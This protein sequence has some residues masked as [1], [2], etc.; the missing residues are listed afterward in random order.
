MVLPLLSMRESVHEAAS[1]SP[2]CVPSIHGSDTQVL[3]CISTLLESQNH[4]SRMFAMKLPN[5]SPLLESMQISLCCAACLATDH[6]ERFVSALPPVC[7]PE[8]SDPHTA[9]IQVHA[10]TGRDATMAQFCK[11]GNYQNLAGTATHIHAC[12]N[13]LLHDAPCASGYS[14]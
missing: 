13:D 9:S 1:L 2:M 4:Y 8:R 7:I 5:G 3:L 10:Q 12:L 14:E 6:P 11:N